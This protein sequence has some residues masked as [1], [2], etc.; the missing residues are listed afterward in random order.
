[1]RLPL[2]S[3]YEIYGGWASVYESFEREAS[4][5][6]WRQGIVEDLRQLGCEAGR[7][8][9]LGAG[10]GIGRHVLSEAFPRVTVISL[11]QSRQMLE[12]G[13]VPVD[14]SIVGDM[15]DFRVAPGSFDFV[16]SGF[17]ALNYL[18]R[19]ELATC[20]ESVAVAL[21]PGGHL[22]FDYSSRQLLQHEWG[23]HHFV[24][25]QDGQRLE[26]QHH[27]DS[28]LDHNRVAL[29][30][31]ASDR[32]LWSETHFHYSVDPF[33]IHELAAKVGLSVTRVRDFGRQTFSPASPTHVYVMQ[34]RPDANAAT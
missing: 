17:D 26:V 32:L 28:V 30:L 12:A 24:R 4:L 20:F 1:M 19:H 2:S 16:V 25:E 18:N 3:G 23:D 7:I 14:Q 22:V 9:D 33:A 27:Y 31:V 13:G 15:A 5:D 6:T 21:R 34:C 10:T 8:L 29:K 11:D